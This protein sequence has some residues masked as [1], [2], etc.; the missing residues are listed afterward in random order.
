MLSNESVDSQFPSEQNSPSASVSQNSAVPSLFN[1]IS[2]I[3]SPSWGSLSIPCQIPTNEGSSSVTTTSTL[4][5]GQ[6]SKAAI[7]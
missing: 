1:T 7:V 2:T 6:P 3:I 4:A 5:A